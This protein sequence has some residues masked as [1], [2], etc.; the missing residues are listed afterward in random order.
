MS[1]LNTALLAGLL[2]AAIPIL[3]HL[4]GRR[5]IKRQPFPTLEFLRRLQNRKMKRLRVRQ[6]LLLAL[7]TLAVLLLAAI[8]GAIVI[9]REK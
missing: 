2:L 9:A 4:L 7:R 5:R 6:W 3:I 1:F 8:M